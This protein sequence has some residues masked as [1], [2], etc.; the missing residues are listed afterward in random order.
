MEVI[1]CWI[2]IIPPFFKRICPQIKFFILSGQVLTFFFSFLVFTHPLPLTFLLFFHSYVSLLLIRITVFQM[3]LLPRESSIDFKPVAL[4]TQA[5]QH[6]LEKTMFNFI[7]YVK[8][9]WSI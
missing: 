9:K 8:V 1:S 2:H 3:D 6:L 4:A 7:N 5:R